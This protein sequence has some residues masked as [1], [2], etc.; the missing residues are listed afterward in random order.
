MPLPDGPPHPEAGYPL[1]LTGAEQRRQLE[2]LE[3]LVADSRR[4]LD[5]PF[6][7]GTGTTLREAVAFLVL[8][9]RCVWTRGRCRDGEP[10]QRRT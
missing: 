6:I 9:L 8:F 7:P 4:F 3:Q 5:A 2:L 1:A 10:E